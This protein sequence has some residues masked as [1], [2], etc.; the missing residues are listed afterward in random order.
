MNLLPSSAMRG[1]PRDRL[2]G[3]GGNDAFQ[4]GK[5]SA[6]HGFRHPPPPRRLR[7]C[8]ILRG[9]EII[10]RA[11]VSD[12]QRPWSLRVIEQRPRSRIASQ[13]RYLLVALD[14]QNGRRTRIVVPT[15]HARRRRRLAPGVV[16]GTEIVRRDAILI[17][18]QNQQRG[19]TQI[20]HVDGMT[21]CCCDPFLPFVV[22][23]HVDRKV[24]DH[25]PVP[26]RITS[27]NDQHS[28]NAC[29]QRAATLPSQ[30]RLTANRHQLLRAAEPA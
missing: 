21:Q 1:D 16:Q 26:I 18:R 19:S 27:E 8:H 3:G 11:R 15:R 23:V 10:R 14:R 20:R 5:A 4:S 22:D 2:G 9:V 12:L 30:Q 17:A 25:A 6:V 24:R 13:P 7:D 28:A 29:P